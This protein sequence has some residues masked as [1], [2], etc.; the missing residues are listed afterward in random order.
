M[1]GIKP[2]S[3]ILLIPSYLCVC[4]S[5][6]LKEK[7]NRRLRGDAVSRVPHTGWGETKLKPYLMVSFHSNGLNYSAVPFPIA[8]PLSFFLL[9]YELL[10]GRDSVKFIFVFPVLSV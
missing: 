9:G 8:R 4:A 7:K 2:I 5:I 10:E 3:N 6:L 1:Q